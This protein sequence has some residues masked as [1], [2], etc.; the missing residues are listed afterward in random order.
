[1]ESQF[2]QSIASLKVEFQNVWKWK[3][4]HEQHAEE[5]RRDLDE[6]ITVL[7]EKSASFGQFAEEVLRRLKD[8]EDLL[9]AQNRNQ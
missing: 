6:K 2:N 4:I 7:K 5:A 8:I 1:M 3:N 9:R